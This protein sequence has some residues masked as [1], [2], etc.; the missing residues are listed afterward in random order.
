MR[1]SLGQVNCVDVVS[2]DLLVCPPGMTCDPTTNSCVGTQSPT[3]QECPIDV[4]LTG[5][6]PCAC[7]PGYEEDAVQNQ[8]VVP[9]TAVVVTDTTAAVADIDSSST[10]LLLALG[11]V[12]IFFFMEGKK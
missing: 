6:T 9:G 4:N 2:G 1:L 3:A 5:Y 12:L 8:C 7:P 10:T 11:A